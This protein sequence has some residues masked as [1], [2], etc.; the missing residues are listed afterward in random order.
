M[1]RKSSR[2]LLVAAGLFSLLV[3][4]MTAVGEE[5]KMDDSKMMM[6]EG[7]A[8]TGDSKMMADAGKEGMKMDDAM[9]A[10]MKEFSTPNENHKQLDKLAGSWDFT[11]KMWMSP[12]AATPEESTGTSDVK[13]ILD[14]RFI[15]ENVTGTSMGQPFTGMGIVGY[16]NIQKQY[17]S[18]WLDN[19]STGMMKGTGSFDAATNTFK[20]SGDFTCPMTQGSRTYHDEI[21]V[22]DENTH[23]MEMYMTDP[24]SGKEFK[25]MELSYTRKK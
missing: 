21:K 23:V 15:E 11:M 9:M 2:N 7:S 22:I 25:T 12:D 3:L 20:Q 4:T 14:G 13:W 10:K 24:A 18:V 6:D 19:M 8:M 1:S 17:N 16:D 5:T